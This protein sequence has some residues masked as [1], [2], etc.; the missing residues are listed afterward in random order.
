[1]AVEKYSIEYPVILDNDKKIW[2]AFEN[3]YWPRKYLADNE[4]YIRYDHI[5]EEK[6]LR[7][8]MIEE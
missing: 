8:K 3:R 1:M 5:G 4:G 6:L 7:R 2:D